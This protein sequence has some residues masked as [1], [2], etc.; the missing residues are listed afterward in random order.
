MNKKVKINLMLIHSINKLSNKGELE[1]NSKKRK[2][3]SKLQ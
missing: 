2:N 3:R 1:N